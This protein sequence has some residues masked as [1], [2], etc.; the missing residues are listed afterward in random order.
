[1]VLPLFIDKCIKQEEYVR[2]AKFYLL[3]LLPREIKFSSTFYKRWWG[4]QRGKAPLRRSPQRVEP[5]CFPKTQE[6]VRKHPT[7]MFS[8]GNPRRGFPLINLRIY[9][10][11]WPHL[12]THFYGNSSVI[13]PSLPLRNSS[14]TV[15]AAR[16]VLISP[17]EIKKP[18]FLP[19]SSSSS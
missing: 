4:F 1:M 14:N 16:S 13:F 7:R 19:T 5:L 18:R 9:A 2:V 8:R 15:M 10:L 11:C 12:L 17:P 6:G 3:H